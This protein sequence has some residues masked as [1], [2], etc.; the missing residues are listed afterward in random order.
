MG[1][2]GGH[3]GSSGRKRSIGDIVSEADRSVAESNYRQAVNQFLKELLTAYD[4]RDVEA[5]QRH[6][7]TIREKLSSEIDGFVELRFGGS[8]TKHTYADG[9]SDVDILVNVRNTELE[10]ASP[11]SLIEYFAQKIRERLPSTEVRTGN[12]AVTVKYSDGAEIQLLPALATRAGVRI[13]KS[14]GEGWSTVVRPMAFAEKL[15]EVNK[16]CGGK[17]VPVIKLYKALQQTM[18]KNC[19]LTGYHVESIA[20]NAFRSYPGGRTHKEMLAHLCKSAA[21]AVKTPI[22]DRTGQSLHVDT[23]LGGSGSADRRRVS[24]YLTRMA[25]RFGGADDRRDVSAWKRLF[26][27]D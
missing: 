22:A 19:Q 10:N 11:K 3:S 16:G 1:G 24:A 23:Y 25:A 14:S 21:K 7:E 27:N 4:Q 12:M 18:P 15:T 26:D 8:I 13:A 5:V 9:L 17:I 2:S 20:V 6:L